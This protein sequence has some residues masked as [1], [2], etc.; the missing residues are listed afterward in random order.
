VAGVTR[1][2]RARADVER[3]TRRVFANALVNTA[4]RNGPVE[5]IHADAFRGYPLD[6]HRGARADDLGEWT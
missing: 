6:A 2:E 3:H 5:N 1:R 4:W